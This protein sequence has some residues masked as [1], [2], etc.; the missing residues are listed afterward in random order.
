MVDEQQQSLMEFRSGPVD[1]Q[2]HSASRKASIEAQHPPSWI[3]DDTNITWR[4][5]KD[6]PT[7]NL[8]YMWDEDALDWVLFPGFPVE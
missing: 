8:P 7:D 4:P 3:W 5:P 2:A 6:P 1:E